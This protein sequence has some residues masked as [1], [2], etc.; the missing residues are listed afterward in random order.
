MPSTH[1][2]HNPGLEQRVGPEINTPHKVVE[3]IFAAA[4]LDQDGRISYDDLKDL[5]INNPRKFS[6]LGLNL[7]FL[8]T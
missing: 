3:Q 2:Q 7:I 5:M 6:Y 4:D 8:P 1:S